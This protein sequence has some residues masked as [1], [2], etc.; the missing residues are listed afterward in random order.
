MILIFLYSLSH[1]TAKHS[2]YNEH[3]KGDASQ[4]RLVETSYT[5][6]ISSE[7]FN[8]LGNVENI[9]PATFDINGP[10]LRVNYARVLSACVKR[11]LSKLI[12]VRIIEYES[13]LCITQKY[14]LNC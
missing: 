6:D 10:L 13:I 7:P 3:E 11:S 4:N 12:V 1:G 5:Y 14:I 9:L 8:I 2:S